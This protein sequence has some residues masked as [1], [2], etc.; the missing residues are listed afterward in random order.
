MLIQIFALR[1]RFSDN[2]SHQELLLIMLTTQDVQMTQKMD[3]FSRIR[4]LNSSERLLITAL[5]LIARL[6]VLQVQLAL[7]LTN[8]FSQEHKLIQISSASSTMLQEGKQFSMQIVFHRLQHH[9]QLLEIE[10]YHQLLKSH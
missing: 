2:V 4:M 8:H 9:I 6:L 7:S 1:T 10:S 3:G 5:D